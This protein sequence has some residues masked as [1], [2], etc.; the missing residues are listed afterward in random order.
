MKKQILILAFFLMAVFAGVNK[1]YGQALS[2][3]YT[4]GTPITA[5]TCAANADFLHPMAGVPYTYQMDG[6]AGADPAA[7]WTWWATKN[8]AFITNYAIPADSLNQAVGELMARTD[9][10]YGKPTAGKNSVVIEWSSALLNLTKYQAASPAD[11]PKTSTFVVGYATGTTCSDNIKV[12]EINPIINFTLDITNLNPTPGNNAPLG[13]DVNTSH[14]V[15]RV[16]SATYTAGD[17]VM[18]YGADTLYFEV[19]AANF[20]TDFTPV[21]RMVSGLRTV[22]TAVITL[23]STLGAARAGSGILGTHNWASTDVGA[24]GDWTTSAFT[25][26]NAADV[27][28]GVSLYVRVVITNSTEESLT[29]NPFVLAVDARDNGNAGIWDMEDADCTAM[30]SA[31]DQVDQAQHTIN[32][33]PTITGTD[34]TAINP[35]APNNI[36][37]K[38]P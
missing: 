12:Y 19:A 11:D 10:N 16:R 30:V 32:P 37:P 6:S 33:R 24:A 27:V 8:P 4:A 26:A 34:D 14:C 9:A 7:T 38:N 21:F 13:W 18:N 35:A 25:A 23:H 1:S 5:L 2:P 22:Q 31:A 3:H 28:T 15:D 36:I 20:N 17:L 29:A